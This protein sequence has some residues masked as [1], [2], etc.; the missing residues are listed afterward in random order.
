[1]TLQT[2]VACATL[3][4]SAGAMFGSAVTPAVTGLWD[5]EEQQKIPVAQWGAREGL[6]QEVYYAGEPRQGRPTRVFAYLGRPAA[7]DDGPVSAQAKYPAML[8][9]HGGGGGAFRAWA[10]HWAKRGYVAIA[11]DLAGNGPGK[12]RLPDGGP[13]L[14]AAHIFVRVNNDAAVRESWPYHAVTAA[15]RAHSLLASLPEVDATRIGITGISWGGFATCIVTGLDRR[16]KVAI[17]VYG[18]G[19]LHENSTWKTEHLDPMTAAERAQWIRLCDAST[20]LP[21]VGC[22]ILFL[23]GTND[24]YY[25]LDSHR[26][27]FLRVRPELRHLAVLERMKHGHV[28]TFPEVDRFVDSVLRGGPPTPA[29]GAMTVREGIVHPKSDS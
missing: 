3:V 17:P 25:P 7:N 19:F 23:T 5:L 11:M 24:R 22:P 16:L 14:N 8:L 21:Q 12:V 15:L 28:W 9:L 2:L 1:M 4:V 20:Y 6:V 27:S 13:Q 26:A 18:S 10:E 29:V